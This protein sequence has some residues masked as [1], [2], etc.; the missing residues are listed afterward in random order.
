MGTTGPRVAG[1][2]KIQGS[3]GSRYSS[4]PGTGHTDTQAL[5][6]ADSWAILLHRGLLQLEDAPR[7]P[8]VRE[9]FEF[10]NTL[11]L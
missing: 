5:R 10:H 8:Y 1:V 7:A 4:G 2:S 3:H 9:E 11:D 6:L